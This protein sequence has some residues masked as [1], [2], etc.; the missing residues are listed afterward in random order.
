MRWLTNP[1]VNEIRTS[2]PKT[3]RCFR[4]YILPAGGRVGGLFLAEALQTLASTNAHTNLTVAR[5]KQNQKQHHTSKSPTYTISP[6]GFPTPVFARSGSTSSGIH[7]VSPKDTLCCAKLHSQSPTLKRNLSTPS[8]GSMP[9]KLCQCCCTWR[10]RQ[11][12]T[13]GDNHILA[14]LNI[15]EKKGYQAPLLRVTRK[16]GRLHTPWASPN[17][18]QYQALNFCTFVQLLPCLVRDMS[19][20]STCQTQGWVLTETLRKDGW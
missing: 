19:H 7:R 1:F 2:I 18:I 10:M 6:L 13:Q 16:Q 9:N 3:R 5:K 20:E 17:E 15:P 12:N 11:T 8:Q 4:A 14:W